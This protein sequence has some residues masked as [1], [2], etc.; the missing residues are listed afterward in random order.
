MA[1]I[2]Q[3]AQPAPGQPFPGQPGL[4]TPAPAQKSGSRGLIIGLAVGAVA[5]ILLLCGVVTTVVGFA[6]NNDSD[7]PPRSGS[8]TSTASAS[9]SASGKPSATAAKITL[10]APEQIGSLKKAANQASAAPMLE[11]MRNAGVEQPFAA[12]YEDTST[13]GRRVLL[14]GGVGSMF[15]LIGNEA[16]L[17]SFFKGALGQFGDGTQSTPEEV[18]T[19]ALG[20]TMRCSS[21]GEDAGIVMATCVWVGSGG[22]LGMTFP[23]VDQATGAQQAQ[24]ILP[25]VVTKS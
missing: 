15:S 4:I 18:P 7:A 10:V 22:L 12:V 5:L 6:V 9:P 8:A 2:I 3:V 13:P 17:D 24:T 20:G 16:G 23:G 21:L 1:P 19:G 14:W 25:A 11:K